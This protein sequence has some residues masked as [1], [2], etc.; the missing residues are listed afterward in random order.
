[1]GS[2]DAKRMKAGN[3][4]SNLFDGQGLGQNIA[5]GHLPRGAIKD[6]WML[7]SVAKY[8]AAELLALLIINEAT[9]STAR[10]KLTTIYKRIAAAEEKA[11]I[12]EA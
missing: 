3:S 4:L 10:F 12:R 9:D 11:K 6:L 5:S 8:R 2:K 7:D 1:M